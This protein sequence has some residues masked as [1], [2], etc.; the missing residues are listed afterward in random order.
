MDV[1]V[2]TKIHRSLRRTSQ[3]LE[4]KHLELGFSSANFGR[5]TRRILYGA[6]STRPLYR[7]DTRSTSRHRWYHTTRRVSE[8]RRNAVQLFDRSDLDD[9]W[10]PFV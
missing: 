9:L 3:P 5:C 1:H 10:H 8:N 7:G 2:K 4:P 6:D